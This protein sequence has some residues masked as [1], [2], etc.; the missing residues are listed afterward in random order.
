MPTLK[1]WPSPETRE[2]NT[3]QSKTTTTA[4]ILCHHTKFE[5]DQQQNL[6]KTQLAILN[7]PGQRN[8]GIR[9]TS[10]KLL[11]KREAK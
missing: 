1:F 5:L 7:I 2:S 8:L 11:R 4:N 6:E 9:S 3:L 10:L